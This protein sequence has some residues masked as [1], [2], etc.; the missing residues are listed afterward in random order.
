MDLLSRAMRN[1]RA[2]LEV[3]SSPPGNTFGDSSIMPNSVTLGLTASGMV[4][5]E[6]G[7]LAISTVLNCMRVLHDDMGLLPFAAYTGD[8][9]GVKKLMRTQ[10]AI[11]AEPFGP[12][13]SFAAG[14]GQITVSLKMRGNAFLYVSDVEDGYPSQ[15][16]ILHP[17]KVQVKRDDKG[18]K[19]FRIN[20]ETYYPDE[21]KHITGMMMPGSIVGI[22]PISYQRMTL[23]LAA[24]VATYGS[25]FFR[26]GGSPSG[27]I[28]VEGA[29]DRKQARAIKEAWESG[30]S[31]VI[32][33]HRPAVLF[34]GATWKQLS[35]APE[36]AQFLQTRGFSR[37]EI[38]GWLGVPLQRIMAIVNNASQGGGNG[39]S[40]I[41]M[42]Y[43]RH[44]LGSVASAIESVWKT[45]LPGAQ[46]SWALFDFNAM[47]RAD[48]LT[49]SKIQQAH[50]LTGIRNRDEI[51]AEEGWAPIGGP[52]GEDYNL[53]FNTNKDVPPLIEPG[54]EPIS[55]PADNSTGG[56]K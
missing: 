30:H 16:E 26:N 42:G 34:G 24:D 50:R 49:R 13:L 9:F 47:L 8:R 29:G 38:C 44:T 7:A 55:T 27:V 1:A 54:E 33:A 51:R 25:N 12:D 41:D 28:S 19:Y 43:A 46:R 6:Q 17:D 56:T 2:A 45:F 18:R 14:I 22:D 48:P 53:P 52:D 40:A 39:L 36:N 4:I 37:E 5:T 35:V 3:R 23:G 20:G 32:N 10:P 11:V 15:L 31:G 21:V